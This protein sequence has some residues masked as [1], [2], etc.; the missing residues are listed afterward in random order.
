MF[1]IRTRTKN[2]I[3]KPPSGHSLPSRCRNLANRA[4]PPP[5]S[6]GEPRR[7]CFLWIIDFFF[8]LLK[9]HPALDQ[10]EGVDD[11]RHRRRFHATLAHTTRDSPQTE[12]LPSAGFCLDVCLVVAVVVVLFG[13]YLYLCTFMPLLLPHFWVLFSNVPPSPKP[14][15]S[16]GV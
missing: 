10:G 1:K 9:K 2:F 15:C 14:A 3:Q 16:C 5:S 8:Q 13:A 6:L 12:M 11:G 4:V 7:Y